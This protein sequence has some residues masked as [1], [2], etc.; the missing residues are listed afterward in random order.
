LH[1]AAGVAAGDG[2]GIEIGFGGDDA[3]NEVRIDP[4]TR[5][6]SRDLFAERGLG[7]LDARDWVEDLFG[8]DASDFRGGQIGGTTLELEVVGVAVELVAGDGETLAR[9]QDDVLGAGWCGGEKG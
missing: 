8:L 3:A 4:V 1:E 2:S 9:A 7:D 5:G 6:G